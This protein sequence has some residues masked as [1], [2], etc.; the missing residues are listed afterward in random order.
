MVALVNTTIELENSCGYLT[1]KTVRSIEQ[2]DPEFIDFAKAY[3]RYRRSHSPTKWVNYAHLTALGALEAALL[4]LT[5]SGSISGL[6]MQ[7]LDEAAAVIRHLYN[8]RYQ[9]KIGR[10]LIEIAIFTSKRKL[11]PVDVSAWKSPFRKVS[12]SRK[13]GLAGRQ[14][15]DQ[16]MP[17]E[18]AL[19]AMA[20]IFANDPSDPQTRCV[21][22]VWALLLSA[23]W[24]ISEV[25]NLHVDAEYEGLDDRGKLSYGFRYYGAKG[26]E[27]DIKWVS[28]IMEPTAREAF[29]RIKEMTQSARDLAAHLESDPEVP[30]RY[31]DCPQVGVHDVLSLE[32]KASY[33]R[34]PPPNS[35]IESLPMWQFKSIAE[36][37]KRALRRL[38]RDFPYYNKET[39][40][41]WSKALFCMHESMLHA[42]H[43]TNYYRLWAP[44]SQTLCVLM[45]SSRV[46]TIF[47]RLGY[48]EPN[49]TPI[50]LT[51]HQARHF[52][53]TIA[54]RGGMAQD[55]LAKWAGRANAKD[56]RVYNHMTDEEKVTKARALT[57][58]MQL[59]GAYQQVKVNAPGTKQEFKLREPGP[60]HKTLFGHCLHD[61]VSSPCDQYRDCLN[62]TKQ[63]YVKGNVDC[64]A[65]IKEKVDELQSQYN[66]ALEA[67][68]KGYAGA[69]RWLEYL[70]KTLFPAK[71]LLEMLES[72]EIEDGTVIRR[73]DDKVLE[74]SHLD[75][76][77][78]QRL[79]Q[80][81]DHSLAQTFQALL[82]KGTN[83]E[84]PLKE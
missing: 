28:K 12:D 23:P 81:R 6:S 62:C 51:T 63:V 34:L 20:E 57:E 25:L 58:G 69:D 21:S 33:L 39:R 45:A 40:L 54:E 71:E 43:G 37:W 84:A 46:K 22:A 55:D 41:T 16:K 19:Y 11:A 77:L 53:S 59:F 2:L 5:K 49:G 13:T 70:S 82:N 50:K 67:M 8:P 56:N 3:Y 66:E 7:M 75:R 68:N 35:P 38:P 26:F 1:V 79:P 15:I 61:W 65:R 64:H 18:A 36:H 83:D 24:R 29:R 31:P 78:D 27:H 60:I 52:V 4:N 48:T 44:T 10:A 73:R 76:A 30:F 9:Y 14:E 42:G 72:D 17:S 74:H 32:D 47:E 80:P